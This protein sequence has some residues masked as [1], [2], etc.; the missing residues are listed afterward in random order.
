MTQINASIPNLIGGVSQQ[1]ELLRLPS[2]M[3]DQV[4]GHSS[5]ATG[6]SKR[7]G[8]A[9][10]GQTTVFGDGFYEMLDYGGRGIYWLHINSAGHVHVLNESGAPVQMYDSTGTPQAGVASS[11]LITG[12]PPTDLRAVKEGDT[13]FLLN[14]TAV[15]AATGIPATSPST[16]PALVWI[17]AGNYG[18]TYK[19]HVP[20]QADASWTTA[21]GQAAWMSPLADTSL[22]AAILTQ[23]LQTAG[24]S[25]SANGSVIYFPNAPAGMTVEDGQ[26]GT[27]SGIIYRSVRSI[28]ELPSSKVPNGFHVKVEGGDATA[29]GDYY[30][31]FD[32]G[33]NVWREVADPLSQTYTLNP[34]TMPHKLTP[35]ANGFMLAPI[36]WDRQKVGDSE[37]NALPY[38]VGHNIHDLF[39]Y[40]DR[41]GL[42]AH[43]GFAFSE[44]GSYYNFFRTTV[45]ELLDSDPLSG[46]I[47]SSAKLSILRHAVAF[48]QRLF[49]F[50][51]TAQFE[52]QSDAAL[53]PKNAST[54]RVTDFECSAT[55]RPVGLGSTLYFPVDRGAWTAFYNFYLDGI[56]SKAQAGDVSGHVPEYVPQGVHKIAISP[57]NNLLIALSQYEPSILYV[58]QFYTNGAERLQSAWHKW[59]LGAGAVVK[60]M[61]VLKTNLYLLIDRPATNGTTTHNVEKI[62]LTAAI[63]YRVDRS[64]EVKPAQITASA[65]GVYPPVSSFALPYMP[66]FGAYFAV[67][68]GGSAKI[69]AGTIRDVQVT[70]GSSTVKVAGDLTGCTLKVGKGY[71]FSA[72]LGCFFVREN[73]G[74]GSAGVTR[75]RTQVTRAWVNYAQAGAFDVRVSRLGYPTVAY[76]CTTKNLGTLSATIGRDSTNSGR[77]AVPVMSRNTSS[78][79]TLI[80]ET[81]N[82][83]SFISIDWEGYHVARGQHV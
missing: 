43:E 9:H 49:L 19:I 59:D 31:Q 10:L 15:A 52:L 13:T 73:A 20:G 61:G 12:W 16:T 1:P 47:T 39:F 58:Y 56:D 82:P 37:T 8:S 23:Q 75:G 60:A 28:A 81:P 18:R 76:R 63:A 32:V 55:V 3:R 22:I 17:K 21:D 7:P 26:G 66:D 24:V 42:L 83:S 70:V 25:C 72:T 78:E 34:A 5:P 51:E 38:F 68:T 64:V 74:A 2:H 14:R 35:Y 50:S 46:N 48:G 65:P 40:Q 33:T 30:L 69:K 57:V 11:Y 53:T 44:S 6:L 29:A 41:L 54:Q 80:N 79:V 45:T 67:V 36:N 27:A 71:T 62:D 4:N 77:F